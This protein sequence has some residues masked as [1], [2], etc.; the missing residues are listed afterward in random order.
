MGGPNIHNL[1]TLLSCNIFWLLPG[2]HVTIVA[3]SRPVGFCLEAAK[4]L[5]AQGIDCEVC[6]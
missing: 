1:L 6:N 2:K 3:H 4:E 5:E